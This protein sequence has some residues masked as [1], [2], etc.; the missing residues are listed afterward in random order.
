MTDHSELV[1][2][3]LT[4][5]MWTVGVKSV[6]GL[7]LSRQLNTSR[8][9]FRGAGFKHCGCFKDI[10]HEHRQDLKCIYLYSLSSESQSHAYYM[11]VVCLGSVDDV[12]TLVLLAGFRRS[13][14]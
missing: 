14:V 9:A 5:P 4:E 7:Q 6:I 1:P 3:S 11:Y 2:V 12:V 8:R 13:V 10:P